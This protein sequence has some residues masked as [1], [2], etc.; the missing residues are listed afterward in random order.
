V[1]F[2]CRWVCRVH[3]PAA[4]CNLQAQVQVQAASTMA[5]VFCN[6]YSGFLIQPEH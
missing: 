2:A 5:A 6:Q 4:S 3:A 1:A